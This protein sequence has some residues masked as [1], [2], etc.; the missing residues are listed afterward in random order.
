MF[1]IIENHQ[2]LFVRQQRGDLSRL[3]T[4]HQVQT[5]PFSIAEGNLR[6]AA[7]RR[8]IH[9]PHTGAVMGQLC[10]TNR[11]GQPDVARPT[12]CGDGPETAVG[13][14]I[15]N[16]AHLGFAADQPSRTHRQ[17][18]QGCIDHPQRCDVSAPNWKSRIGSPTSRR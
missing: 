18:R 15:A 6:T 8:Q 5:K 9:E 3:V 10:L 4:G 14:H 2:H 12:N 11:D 17:V 7:P 16:T 13:E 1:A